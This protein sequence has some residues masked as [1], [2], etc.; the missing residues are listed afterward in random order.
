[1]AFAVGDTNDLSVAD[2][3]P[4]GRAGRAAPKACIGADAD[5]ILIS[6]EF[7]ATHRP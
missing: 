2:S 6:V 4:A 7:T 3:I 1:M 5:S